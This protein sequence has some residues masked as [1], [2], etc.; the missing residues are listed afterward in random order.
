MEFLPLLFGILGVLIG[1]LS[2]FIIAMK[3]IKSGSLEHKKPKKRKEV[4]EEKPSLLS[5]MNNQDY[6]ACKK[7][8]YDGETIGKKQKKEDSS[9]QF[10]KRK[11]D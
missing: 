5:R 1:A 10:L 11:K 2:G 9:Y 4:E 3:L 6:A 7:P 8:D